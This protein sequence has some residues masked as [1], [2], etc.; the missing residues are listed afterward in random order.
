MSATE[1]ADLPAGVKDQLYELSRLYGFNLDRRSS[2]VICE[3]L[4]QHVTPTGILKM[5]EVNKL[6]QDQP[7]QGQKEAE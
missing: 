7:A 3:M 5:L 4:N 1:Q 6:G 2:D